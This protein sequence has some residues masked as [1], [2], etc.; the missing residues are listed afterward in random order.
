MFKTKTDFCHLWNFCFSLPWHPSIIRCATK[1]PLFVNR[2]LHQYVLVDFEIYKTSWTKLRHVVNK[3]FWHISNFDLA[4]CE[5]VWFNAKESSF[6][7]SVNFLL[8]FQEN[9]SWYASRAP[10]SLRR[11]CSNLSERT[12]RDWFRRFKRRWFRCWRP[13]AWRQAKNL[14]RR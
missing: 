10:K 14:R 8:S 12:S 6:A 4:L 13:S 2:W 3:P 9:G 1:F 7:G 11:C 5:N